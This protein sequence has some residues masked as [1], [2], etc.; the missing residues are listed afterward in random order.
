MASPSTFWW[1][2]KETAANEFRKLSEM[3]EQF[4]KGQQRQRFSHLEFHVWRL[5]V[6][7]PNPAQLRECLGESLKYSFSRSKSLMTPTT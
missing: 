5:R 1:Q 7:A 3:T 6:G 4:S 2:R